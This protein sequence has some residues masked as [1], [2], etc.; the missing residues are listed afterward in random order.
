MNNKS[1][2]L[3]IPA[4]GNFRFSAVR[5]EELGA[6]EYTLVT[7]AVDTSSSVDGFQQDLLNA[8]KAVIQSCQRHARADNLLVRLTRFASDLE[9]LFGFKTLTDVDVDKLPDLQ[10]RGATALYD[11]AFDAL[12]ATEQYGQV[13][14]DQDF[15]VNGAVFVITDGLD[16]R[17]ATATPA[18][19]AARL[20][21]IRQAESLE[22]ML[23]LLI[24]VNTADSQAQN[25]LQSLAQ[26]AAF[27]QYI[28]VSRASTDALARL[29]GFVSKSISNQSQALG[30][31]GPS[32]VLTF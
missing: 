14:Y 23:A 26:E 28:D 31:G 13:L 30:S 7:I 22:S 21:A 6:A 3:A 32:Q 12:A 4:A 27:D 16:N 20:A 2:S 10:P 8:I 18:L 29:A 19:L 25:A 15:D 1:M 9:E 24:G 11:A 5:P 17:S